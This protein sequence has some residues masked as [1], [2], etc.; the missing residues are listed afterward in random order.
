[1]K[2][3]KVSIIVAIYN[4]D[5][6]LEQCIESIINQ[7]YKNIEIILVNDCSTDTSLE[8]CNYYK[9]MDDRINLITHKQNTKA[10]GVRNTGIANSTG[11]YIVFV[12]GDDWLHHTFISYMLSVITR[13][14]TSIAINLSNF[15]SRDLKDN[16]ESEIQIWDTSKALSEFM[17]PKLTIGA[18][19]KIYSKKIIKDHNLKFTE[20]LYTA[21][22][23]KFVTECLQLVDKVAVADKKLYYYRLN[24]SNSAT[25]KYDVNQS[26]VSIEVVEGLKEGLKIKTPE[27]LA[28][29]DHHIWINHFWNIRQII[30][31]DA[32]EKYNVEYK[33]SLSFVRRKGWKVI[34]NEKRVSKKVKYILATICPRTIARLKN[35]K[36]DRQLLKDI[37]NNSI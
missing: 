35:R 10:S 2:E 13:E 28:A 21:E 12:D 3:C 24:N 36:T 20:G 15:T 23:Y 8:I 16:L 18:W 11:D 19:N 37:Q 29:V 25:T 31:L 22:G 4:V 9:K 1:M 14:N 32:Y 17:Y 27:V 7:D 5:K 33:T 6:F 30:A 34:Y 26:L